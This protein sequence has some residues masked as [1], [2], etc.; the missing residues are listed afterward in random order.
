MVTRSTLN[1]PRW[2]ALSLIGLLGLC[3]TFVIGYATAWGP[4]VFS[5]AAGY[6]MIAGNVLSGRGLGSIEASGRFRVLSMQPPL[7]PLVL[8]G[9]GS[10]GIN[11]AE[12]ARWL[13]AVLFGMTIVVI[14]L[15]LFW[16]SRS[17]LIAF[18][19]C[20]LMLIFPVMI[21]VFST[22]MSEPIFFVVSITGLFSLLAYL[23]RRKITFLILSAL[24]AGLAFLTRY[25]GIAYILAG[26][27]S[28]F[29]FSP[30]SWKRRIPEIIAYLVVSIMP[31]AVWMFF[32]GT[33]SFRQ[34]QAGVNY[35]ER[36]NAARL[37]FVNL[38]WN[39]IPF[40]AKLPAYHYRIKLFVLVALALSM[41]S[42]T[43][44]ALRKLSKESSRQRRNLQDVQWF[45]ALVIYLV[46]FLIA[47]AAAYISANPALDLDDRQLSSAYPLLVLLFLV[48]CHIIS[49][50]WRSQKWLGALPAIGLLIFAVAFL[51][52]NLKIVSAYHHEGEGY[53]SVRWRNSA[54]I[55]VARNFPSTIPL[56]SNEHT[57]C[58]FWVGRPCYPLGEVVNEEP[59]SVYSRFGDDLEDPAQAAFRQQGAALILFD[60][61]RWQ[62]DPLYFEKTPQRL[63]ALTSGLRVYGDYWDGTIYFYPTGQNQ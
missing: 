60:T 14:G 52:E 61:I 29:I 3:G 37:E 6:I 51:P 20:I 15:P 33:T 32:S 53:L 58:S 12:A 30:N 25:I 56:I 45:G 50:A 35:W 24:M 22:A 54:T 2:L 27:V 62:L 46:T 59:L 21:T 18:V 16:Y 57:A 41:L 44:L 8:A 5:D 40:A 42:A 31:V 10:F 28:L 38:L 36:L 49:Q 23:E 34:V 4:V 7:F 48:T 17:L 19:G 26:G 63:E 13:N 47:L 43:T 9:L 1:S 11:L 55:R 39:W